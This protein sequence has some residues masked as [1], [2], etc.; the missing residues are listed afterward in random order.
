MVTAVF[1]HAIVCHS[2][3]RHGDGPLS[4]GYEIGTRPGRC[5]TISARW[6]AVF[7]TASALPAPLRKRCSRE[8]TRET[9]AALA[10]H[11]TEGRPSLD[12]ETGHQPEARVDFDA[13]HQAAIEAG[14]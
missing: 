8:F 6:W 7:D 12:F 4:V 2:V 9:G 5:V 10:L 3:R 1:R 14:R 13:L 11:D